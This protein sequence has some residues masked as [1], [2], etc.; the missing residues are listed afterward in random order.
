MTDSAETL[1]AGAAVIAVVGFI[2]FFC[3]LGYAKNDRGSRLLR[4][5][6]MDSRRIAYDLRSHGSSDSLV[7][8]LNS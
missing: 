8:V 6:D 5:R 7:A 3:G 2:L 4:R 1:L